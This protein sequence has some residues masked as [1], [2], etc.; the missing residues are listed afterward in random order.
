[1]KVYLVLYTSNGDMSGINSGCCGAYTNRSDAEKH[2]AREYAQE[3]KE[4]TGYYDREE[5]V[6]GDY[7]DFWQDGYHDLNHYHMWVEENELK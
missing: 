6:P 5:Y 7:F 4:A 2:L 1:M 3:K